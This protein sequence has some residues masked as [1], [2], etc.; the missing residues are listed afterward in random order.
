MLLK[1]AVCFNLR[2]IHR[3]KMKERILVT[4]SCGQ[5]GTELVGELRKRFGEGEVLATD[6]ANPQNPDFPEGPFETL[7]VLDKKALD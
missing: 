4:G 6:L 5:L 7:N 3:V 2:P 1:Q